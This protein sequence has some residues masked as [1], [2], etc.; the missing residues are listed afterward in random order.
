MFKSE[1]YIE[2]RKK[3]REK[4]KTG[5]ALFLGNED[6]PMNYPANVYPHFRQDSSFL[7]YFGLDEPGLT[8]I[9]D[10]DE[11]RE[12]IFGTDVTIEDIIWM[13][14][15]PPL[16][17]KAEKVGVTETAPP[18]KLEEILKNAIE[19][20]RKI[21]YLPPYR[22]EHIVKLSK[23]LGIS[24]E[25]AKSGASV[26]L[27]K[28]VVEMRSVKSPE[29]VAE[30]ERAMDITKAIHLKAMEMTKPGMREKEIA[31]IMEGLAI[32]MGGYLSFP[33]ILT[34]HGEILH[35]SPTENVIKEGDLVLVDAGGESPLHYAGDMTRTFPAG[36]K[37][38]TKQREIYS[39]VL[40]AQ[41]KAIE[42]IKPG[43][44]Y[45]EIHLMT[46]KNMAS[47]LKELGLM[48]GDIE[49]AVAAGAHALFFPHGLGHMMGLDVHDM[50]NLGED[51][52]GYNHTVKR[53]EQFGLAYL[54]LAKELKPGFVLTVEPGIYF[55]PAL[56]DQWK[57]EGKH[58]AFINYEKV[59]EYKG[60]GGIRIEDDVLVTET[61]HRVLGKPVPKEI[62]D[63]EAI[64]SK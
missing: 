43:I 5:I 3:L 50:E 46:A 57:A 19:R 24:H 8:A 39:I 48:K 52:V 64:R 37:F 27:I 18:E 62:D 35:N 13:G 42:A 58:T 51:Y 4:V 31:G 36:K 61:G 45:K 17:E 14:F 22:A 41:M 2:R 29:E 47:G 10:F 23:L 44:K 9:I 53:S 11:G 12:I 63:V 25:E 20:G 55:I 26:D 16:K 60:F 15:L 40:N 34:T 21:H 6:V 38:S 59:E 56:I 33:I 1:T 7:Y 30:I 54:R 28:A 32:S 49:E